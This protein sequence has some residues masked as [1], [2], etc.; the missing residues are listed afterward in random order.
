MKKACHS[1]F[2]HAASFIIKV[3]ATWICLQFQER[4]N[5]HFLT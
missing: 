3:S 2:G 4:G 1:L 5:I